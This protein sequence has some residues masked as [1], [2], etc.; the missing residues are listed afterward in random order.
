MQHAWLSPKVSAHLSKRQEGQ[1]EAR[2]T[3]SWRV[4]PRLHKRAW[5]LTRRGVMKGKVTV[6]L[7]REMAG[8]AWAL[9][10]TVKWPENPPPTTP[11]TAT[12]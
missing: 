1:P 7:A 4:Q 10:Q 12:G 3:L 5:Q 8:F 11:L 2:K 9:L 6:A